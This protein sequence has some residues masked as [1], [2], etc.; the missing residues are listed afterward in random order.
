MPY[1]Q[2]NCTHQVQNFT[3]ISAA[4]PSSVPVGSLIWVGVGW[5]DNSAP[6]ADQVISSVTGG[7]GNSY[8]AGT[9]RT[10]SNS[11]LRLQSYYCINQT[12][13]QHTIQV[14]FD[15][16]VGN[17]IFLFIVEVSNPDTSSPFI[18]ES[19]N[20][21][22]VGSSVNSGSIL[23]LSEATV[24]S[25]VIMLSGGRVIATP[26]DHTTLDTPTTDLY[27]GAYREVAGGGSYNTT[28]TWTGGN[29]NAIV[30]T[31]VIKAAGA[32]APEE[33]FYPRIRT[34]GLNS[35]LN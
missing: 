1:V 10:H 35:R 29:A 4:F 34:R 3:T 30:I 23:V 5:W 18:G 22:S 20:E 15:K 12:A 17:R 19:S 13:G 2:S 7:T 31:D 14:D 21:V 24:L 11:Q 28:W 9:L 16:A 33:F 25:M 8:T 6:F 26:T 32:A 27:E